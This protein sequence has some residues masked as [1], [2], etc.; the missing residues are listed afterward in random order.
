MKWIT[1][2]R[3]K[4]DRVAC[5]WLIKRFIDPDAEFLFVPAEE[6]MTVGNEGRIIMN[7]LE[8][9][10]RN[11]DHRQLVGHLV[12]QCVKIKIEALFKQSREGC[13]H[14]DNLVFAAFACESKARFTT[15]LWC[16][17]V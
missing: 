8:W 9:I 15:K 17:H 4:V 10:G 3:V 11:N 6:V 7:T 13:E 12:V 16:L 14:G 1:R 2:E 5:P